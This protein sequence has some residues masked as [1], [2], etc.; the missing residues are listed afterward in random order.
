MIVVDY[1]VMGVPLIAQ[2]N[3]KGCWY[4]ST[5]MLIQWR[6][7]RFIPGDKILDPSE[8]PIYREMHKKDEGLHTKEVVEYAKQLGLR[9][10]TNK[11]HWAD[12]ICGM[13]KRYGPLWTTT[14]KHV[15]VIVGVCG[16]DLYVHDPYPPNEGT[17]R[18]MSLVAYYN[19]WL[20]RKDP[21][22]RIVM[23]C[24]A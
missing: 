19:M 23:H 4:A 15:M 2:T 16:E 14:Y 24:P 8:D 6:R 7:G 9:I 17:K 12:E 20:E 13:L 10:L 21:D 1:I 11:F 3:E 5:Q 18:W 22:P